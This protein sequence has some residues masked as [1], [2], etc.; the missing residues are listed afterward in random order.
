MRF[1]AHEY[2]VLQNNF[3]YSTSIVL[4]IF[5]FLLILRRSTVS[6]M[7]EHSIRLAFY[8]CFLG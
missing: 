4:K 7:V 5:D 6:V 3:V 2:F 8:N 1:K